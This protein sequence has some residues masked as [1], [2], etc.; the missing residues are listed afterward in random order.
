MYSLWYYVARNHLSVKG[1]Y[2]VVCKRSV[3][4]NNCSA[5]TILKRVIKISCLVMNHNIF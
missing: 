3:E 5:Y 2:S 1:A 4:V